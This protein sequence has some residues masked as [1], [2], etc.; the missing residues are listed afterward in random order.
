MADIGEVA[1]LVGGTALIN[2]AYAARHGVSPVG[3]LVSAGLTMG[4]LSLVGTLWRWDVCVA[5]AGL[6]LVSSAV[7]RGIPLIEDATTL[8]SS[9]PAK[10]KAAGGFSGSGGTF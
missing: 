8:A 7:F 6:F 1:V 3:P 2:T 9:K 4:A 10:N 5:L